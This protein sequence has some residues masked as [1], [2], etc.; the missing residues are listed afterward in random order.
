MPD[1][2]D[3]AIFQCIILNW[4][5]IQAWPVS[6]ISADLEIDRDMGGFVHVE[7]SLSQLILYYHSSARQASMPSLTACDSEI[8]PLISSL[9]KASNL[10]RG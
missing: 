5:D 1:K 8:L 10:F 6:A 2:S 7:S 4:T 3:L 9:T